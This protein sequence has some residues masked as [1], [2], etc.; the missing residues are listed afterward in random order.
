M[1]NSGLHNGQKIKEKLNFF[2]NFKFFSD[3]TKER[4]SS[5]LFL[6]ENF[7]VKRNQIIYKEGDQSNYLYFIKQGEVEVNNQYSCI[8]L[9]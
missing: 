8:K 6:F 1:I 3:F 7:D 4:M 2:H 5:L 9:V